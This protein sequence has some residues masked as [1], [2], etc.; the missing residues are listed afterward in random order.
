MPAAPM[1]ATPHF[2]AFFVARVVVYASSQDFVETALGQRYLNTK[3]AFMTALYLIPGFSTHPDHIQPHTIPPKKPGSARTMRVRSASFRMT[4]WL[5][6]PV[7]PAWQPSPRR[8][9]A[10][11]HMAVLCSRGSGWREGG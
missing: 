3:E 7:M 4:V 8:S 5:R 9:G 2:V 1:H 10:L 11:W 6:I